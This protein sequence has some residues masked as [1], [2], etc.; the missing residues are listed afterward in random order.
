MLDPTALV[1]HHIVWHPIFEKWRELLLLFI[2]LTIVVSSWEG[3]LRAVP[4]NPLEDTGRFWVDIFLVFTYL[5]MTLAT[6]DTDTWFVIHFIVF[7]EYLVWDFLRMRLSS[8]KARTH[9]YE[10]SLVITLIWM[11]YFSIILYFKWFFAYFDGDFGFAAISASVLSGVF[12]Y[13]WDKKYREKWTWVIKVLA[14]T[15]PIVVLLL[16]AEFHIG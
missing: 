3:Y 5:F 6:E 2:S 16:F 1:D 4:G 13:R 10:S 9:P 8:F 14:T 15:T 7:G 11:I 12:L